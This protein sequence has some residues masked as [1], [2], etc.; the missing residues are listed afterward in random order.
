VVR[1]NIG[2]IAPIFIV[3]END[4]GER[5][6]AFGNIELEPY[7]AWNLD[8]SAEWYFAPSAVVQ[9][10]GF[11]KTIENFIVAANFE[12]GD[13]PY[14]GVFNGVPFDE[15][16]IPINGEDATVQGLEFNYQ[17]AL[18]MLPAPLD[19]LLV[20]F[21]YTYTDAEGDVDGRTI[22]LPASSKHNFNAMLG[23]EKGRVS[24]RFT[25]AFRD[26]FLDSL[27]GSP[28]EDRY[29][30]DHLQI[31][32]RARYTLAERFQVFADLVNLN[33]EPFVAFQRGPGRDRL[34]QF[35]TYSWTA[36]AG[37]RATF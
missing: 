6:G 32:L 30:K 35:E 11:Y 15:A 3:E 19:G 17:H 12:A 34:L 37:I 9:V 10:G 5:E 14:M 22:P 27:E 26:E 29:V 23:F 2:Q 25:A 31:D 20:G 16:E 36:I 21:N 13:P 4:E 7:R 18:A 1:P 33:N 24:V 28:E 8:F